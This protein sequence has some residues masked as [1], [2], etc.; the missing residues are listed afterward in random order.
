MSARCLLGG[1]ETDQH[2]A[3]LADMKNGLD[4]DRLAQSAT[5]ST[6]LI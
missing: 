1:S 2:A 6:A 3:A 4:A 5:Q